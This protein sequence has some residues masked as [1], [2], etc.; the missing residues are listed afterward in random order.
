MNAYKFLA[1]L[2]I[3]VSMDCVQ[4]VGQTHDFNWLYKA[5]KAFLKRYKQ[6]GDAKDLFDANDVLRFT[7]KSDFKNL[8]ER[9]SQ[10]KS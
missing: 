7:I 2:F 5:E 10:S 9:K 1:G 6:R 4:S 3:S 8:I